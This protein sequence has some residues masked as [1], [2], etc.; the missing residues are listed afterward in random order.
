MKVGRKS[1][2]FGGTTALVAGAALALM[3]SGSGASGQLVVLC[4]GIPATIIGTADRDVLIG[5]DGPDV[6]AGLDGNDVLRGLDGDDTICGD[7]GRDRL[8][9]GKGNDTI[10]GGKKNDIVKGDQGRDDL[11]GNQGNDRLR[12]GG[13]SDLLNGGSGLR[14]QLDGKGGSDVCTDRQS[15]TQVVNC[16]DVQVPQPVDP[17]PDDTGPTGSSDIAV[18]LLEAAIQAGEAD[19]IEGDFLPGADDLASARLVDELVGRGIDLSGMEIDV[20]PAG[21]VP[22][23]ALL[24]TDDDTALLNEDGGADAFLLA[25]L[26]TETGID[27]IVLQHSSSDDDGPY[28]LTITLRLEDLQRAVDNGTSVFDDAAAQVERDL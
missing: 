28:L 4:N 19:P 25:L 22:S 9:G 20:Y 23:F 3:L 12:G 15:T 24:R 2:A 21:S 18:D 16:E 5:T 13:G 27:R 6:M 7:N 14:D 11:H 10:L 8:F 17:P 1:F 26:E